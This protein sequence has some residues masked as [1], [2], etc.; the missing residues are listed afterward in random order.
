MRDALQKAKLYRHFAARG[1]YALPEI[2]VFYKGGLR[3][4]RRLITDVDMLA[5]RPSASLEWEI[6][7]GDCKTLKDVSPANRAVWLRGMMAHFSADNGIIVLKRKLID[8]DHKLFASSFGVTL[9]DEDEFEHYDRALI[10]PEGS[11]RL[12]S[13]LGEHQLVRTLHEKYPRLRPFTDYLF[14]LAWNEG[15]LLNLLRRVIGE[16]RNVSKEI[17][18]NNNAHLALILEA[19]AIFSVGLARCVGTIFNQFLQ[20]KS[21]ANLDEGL[22]ILIWGGRDQYSFLAKVRHDMIASKGRELDSGL[23]LPEWDKF[24][25]LVREMLECPAL[26]FNLP[27]LL[28]EAS[29]CVMK[30]SSFLPAVSQ[31]QLLLLKY[32]MITVKYVC[33]AGN[34]PP[35]AERVLTKLFVQR[36]SDLLYLKDSHITPLREIVVQAEPNKPKTF[37][38]DAKAINEPT[39]GEETR[40]KKSESINEQTKATDSEASDKQIELPVESI[41]K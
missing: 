15:E 21:K 5:L 18:P 27:Q 30:N 25:E 31:S 17:D 12:D 14:L 23:T 39:A 3:D 10:Y 35:D 41:S 9:L 37:Q 16:A 20:L 26:G 29:A 40:S 38:S 6:V 36:Q 11:G 7:L 33:R 34:F 22:R 1:W 4:T 32:A 13:T 8:E 19:A 2:P 24:L 28:R